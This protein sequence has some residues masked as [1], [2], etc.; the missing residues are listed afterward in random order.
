MDEEFM[1]EFKSILADL[2][3]KKVDERGFRIFMSWYNFYH[4]LWLIKRFFIIFSYAAIVI[5]TIKTEY[6]LE[7]SMMFKLSLLSGLFFIYAT[8][9][10]VLP[11]VEGQKVINLIKKLVRSYPEHYILKE[12]EEDGRNS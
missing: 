7:V 12:D 10:S 2:N 3:V 4:L 8:I 1:E 6:Q 11:Y 9:F 5:L